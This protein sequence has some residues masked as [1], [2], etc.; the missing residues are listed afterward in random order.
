M[1]GNAPDY[2]VRRPF[3]V[4]L[5]LSSLH[6]GG[7]ERVAVHL[8]NQVDKSRHDVRMGLLRGA[9]PY[10]DRADQSRVIVAPE[11]E[12]HFNYDGPNSAQYAP[13]KIIGS[14]DAREQSVDD[15]NGCRACRYE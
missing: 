3:K 4:L 9:G 5:L 11:G 8:L 15:A 2:V 12:T 6:G 14:A 7:A 1:H 13:G 10:F